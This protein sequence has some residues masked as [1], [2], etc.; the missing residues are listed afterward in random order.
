M[1]YKESDPLQNELFSLNKDQCFGE[2]ALLSD[3]PRVCSIKAVQTTDL[4]VVR[5]DIYYQYESVRL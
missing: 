3:Q 2:M 1:G 5:K 4:I